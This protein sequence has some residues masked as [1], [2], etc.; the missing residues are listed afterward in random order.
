MGF[1]LQW[2]LPSCIGDARTQW[3]GVY[4]LTRIFT[5]FPHVIVYAHPIDA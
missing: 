1:G 5:L 4:E 3:M 2:A